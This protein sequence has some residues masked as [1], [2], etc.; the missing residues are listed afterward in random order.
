[1]EGFGALSRQVDGTAATSSAFL[2]I[3]LGYNIES[4]TI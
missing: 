3:F 4:P 2:L 1:M